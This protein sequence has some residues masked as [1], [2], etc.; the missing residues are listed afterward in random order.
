MAPVISPVTPSPTLPDATTVVVIGGGMVGLTAAL[1]LAERNIPV[2]VLEKGRIAGEQSSRNLG[3][4]RKT[5]RAL[6]DIPLAQAADRLW[7]G[8]AARV[9]SDVG[10]RQAGIMF[11]ARNEQQMSLHEKWLS[12]VSAAGLDTRLLSHAQIAA[13][14]PGGAEKWAGGIYT[15]SDGRAEPTLA[16][17]AMANAAIAR[18]A[19]IMDHCAVRGLVT[20]NGKV[21]GVMTERGEIRC[22]QVLLAAGAWSRRFLGNHGINLPTL[23]LICSVMRTKPLEG[24]ANIAV[25]APDFSFRKHQDGGFIITQRGALDAPITL[26]HLL[27]GTRYMP[28]LRQAR[29]NLRISL[30]K[31]FVKDL[32]LARR[33]RNDRRSP[34]E[35]VRTLD[36]LANP[37]LNQEAMRNLRAA[38]PVFQQAEMAESWAGVI[39]VTPDSNPVIGPVASIPGLTLATG[40]SGHGF[41]T[42]PAAGQLAADLVTG[43]TPLI[44][45]APYRFERLQ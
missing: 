18:G 5:S 29:D 19:I 9:G 1:T 21:S 23:P 25:G 32:A 20:S 31:Y 14:V 28:Q 37:A 41:G 30:G 26:D 35:Q 33:W 44:D 42:S 38:W 7:A 39:D 8:M 15:A 22:D 13:Q 10:Y 2:V 24:P 43:H 45:P 4:I 16:A 27:I 17:S 40:F 3:W 11:V 6:E 34:F 36:P 12:G